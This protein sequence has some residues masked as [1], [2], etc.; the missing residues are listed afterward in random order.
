MAA[1]YR[2]YRAAIAEAAPGAG[3][4]VAAGRMDDAAQ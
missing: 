2:P 4:A 3:G 1:E